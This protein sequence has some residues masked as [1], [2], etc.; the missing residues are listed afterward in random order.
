MSWDLGL[1]LLLGSYSFRGI[2]SFDMG[3]GSLK[4]EVRE[5]VLGPV[6]GVFDKLREVGF[7][8]YLGFI[9]IFGTFRMFESI[10]AIRGRLIGPKPWDRIN[11]KF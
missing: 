11:I 5:Q 1:W 10:E 8:P 9:P 3:Q 7:S 2:I 6:L 4:S